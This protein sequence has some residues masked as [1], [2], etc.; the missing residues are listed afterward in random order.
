MNAPVKIACRQLLE[1]IHITN[2]EIIMLVDMII[3]AEK[4]TILIKI[5]V[6]DLLSE[7]RVRQRGLFRPEVVSKFVEEQR[8][9]TQDWSMQVWQFLTLELWMQAFLDGAVKQT[10]SLAPTPEVATA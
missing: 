6:D 5:I 7:T 9:G 2:L 4:E 1:N 3:K 8:R 10:E